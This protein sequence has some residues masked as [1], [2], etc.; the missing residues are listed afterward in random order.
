MSFLLS[1]ADYISFLYGLVFVALGS[2]AFIQK[3]AGDS[4]VRWLWL[5]VFGMLHGLHE[6][7][8]L[9]NAALGQ[10][11][12]VEPLAASL[13]L[14]SFAALIEFAWNNRR[15]TP[16]KAGLTNRSGQGSVSWLPVFAASTGFT[17]SM[18]GHTGALLAVIS[19]TAL[20]GGLWS[21]LVLWTARTA[22]NDP[23]QK[24]CLLI[25][26]LAIG[27]YGINECLMS[28]ATDTHWRFISS[29]T[30]VR[31]SLA[32]LLETSGAGLVCA[33]TLAVWSYIKRDRALE[34]HDDPQSDE[35]RLMQ[36]RY[37]AWLMTSLFI[38]LGVGWY[39]T[40]RLGHNAEKSV[41]DR[42][43]GATEILASQLRD[44]IARTDL[45]AAL[46]AKSPF[47][48]AGLAQKTP[49]ALAEA[50][51]AMRQHTSLLETSTAFLM[52]PNG[53]V[54]ASSESESTEK[55]LGENFGFLPFFQDSS[56][57]GL[58][59]KDLAVEPDLRR[60]GYYVSHPVTDAGGRPLGVAVVKK[61]LAQ[62]NREFKNFRNWFLVSPAG[63]I[64]LS[65]RTD[66]LLRPL[67]PIPETNRQRLIRTRDLGPGPFTGPLLAEAPK[68]RATIRWESA[69]ALANIAP[70][71]NDGW[72]AII[73]E[74]LAELAVHRFYGIVV[75]MA[76]ALFTLSFFVVLQ[77]EGAYER[78]LAI[79]QRRLQTLNAELERQ[80]TTDS[81][82]GTYNRAKFNAAL[83]AEIDRA[84]R[85]GSSF[86][87]IIL[88]VDYFKRVNDT[89]GHQTGDHVLVNLAR[90]TRETIRKSDTLARWGGEEFVIL[91][92]MTEL[93]G[94]VN[95]ARR[96][97]EALAKFNWD[98]VPAVTCSFGVT[99][100][101][102]GDTLESIVH[103]ADQAL[104]AAK[105]LGRNRVEVRLAHNA[106]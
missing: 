39:L 41:R 37:S 51:A 84:K 56:A 94:T 11:F 52:R 29:A 45:M 28:L 93:D 20:I 10:Q 43:H 30:A 68:D 25:T 91:L 17:L 64:F 65:S 80:A 22:N 104:Y 82:T 96:V 36:H 105:E 101:V 7:T 85:Y 90:L 42:S 19:L 44:E 48:Q 50:E 86:A 100:Y 3:F 71:R 26:A 14:A 69:A 46:L 70:V 95:F 38:V 98:P 60:R 58:V 75:T 103:R 53:E 12:G 31:T 63:I 72:S 61:V 15:P 74:N 47:V 6:W 62:S 97:Q 81:L 73:V 1:Q 77:R 33:A 13:A 66:L 88:D 27:L 83:L 78:R 9:A 54:L 23:V 24:N 102:A 59:G 21:A 5:S 67:W 89:W 57:Y 106:A 4:R 18:L 55:R 79:N 8:Q 87:M 76:I 49:E 99:A 2:I 32:A 92:P 40:E 35:A 16:D 34:S